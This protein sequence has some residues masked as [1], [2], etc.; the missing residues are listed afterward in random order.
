LL[1]HH[2][3]RR[4]PR[5][6]VGDAYDKAMSESFFATQECELLARSRFGIID[7]ALRSNQSR[8][9]TTSMMD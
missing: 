8:T 7:G 5:L 3:G 1:L 6:C 4:L 9:S 2:A